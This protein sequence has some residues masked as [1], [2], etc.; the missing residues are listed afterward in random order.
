MV[1]GLQAMN[2]R[3]TSSSAAAESLESYR[4]PQCSGRGQNVKD[5]QQFVTGAWT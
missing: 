1:L 2:N 3:T 4:F 5:R